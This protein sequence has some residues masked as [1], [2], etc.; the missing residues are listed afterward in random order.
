MSFPIAYSGL[1][2]TNPDL[3]Q[4]LASLRDLGW[5]GWETRLSLDWLG[6]ASRVKKL[7]ANANV[8]VAAVCGPN[9]TLSTKDPVQEINKR[10]IEYAAELEVP[11]FMTKGPGRQDRDTTDADLDRMAE[12]YE[13]LAMFGEPLGVTVTYHPHINHVVDSAGEWK[14][15]MPRLSACKLCLDMS[16]AVHWG[17][18]PIQAVHDFKDS[19][20]YIHLHDYDYDK[21][22]TVE[23][24]EGPMCD[25][26]AFLQALKN[27]NFD[28]WI[29]S[30]PGNT[31]RTDEEKMKMNRQY[32]TGIG[33]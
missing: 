2:W 25:Y 24:G 18:N 33:Y 7:C 10:R 14:R 13:D 19:I 9:V 15:F 21:D 28:G 3:E 16:H 23:L 26:P 6:P 12:V 20:A 22:H 8:Q 29:V 31:D 11:L 17:Y 1:Q 27:I 4:K 5:D 30:C 32:L